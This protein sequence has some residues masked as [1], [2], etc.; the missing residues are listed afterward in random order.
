MLDAGG[1]AK[2]EILDS[3]PNR[4]ILSNR[5]TGDQTGGETSESDGTQ[6]GVAV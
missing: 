1:G 2:T 6:V 5:P 3:F 4:C